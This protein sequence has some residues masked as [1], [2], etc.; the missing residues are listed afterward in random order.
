LFRI[1]DFVLRTS[2]YKRRTEDKLDAAWLGPCSSDKQK[3]TAF[4]VLVA[5]AVGRLWTWNDV[6]LVRH[7]YNN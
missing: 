6:L 7:P 2:Y 5:T 3:E 1:S 4:L